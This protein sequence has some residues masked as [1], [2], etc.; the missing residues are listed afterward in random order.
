MFIQQF[1]VAAIFLFLV[2]VTAS[3]C[4]AEENISRDLRR[5]QKSL[6]ASDYENAYKV[7]YQQAI[8]NNN[9]LAEF[10]LALFYE[11]GWGRP[12]DKAAAC[13][14]YGKAAE[15]EIPAAAHFYAQCFE[16]GIGRK[17]STTDAIQW[18]EK[19]IS[20]DHGGSHYPLAELLLSDSDHTNAQQA[21]EHL[22]QAA[23]LGNSDAQME[24]GDF[25]YRGEYVVKNLTEAWHWYSQ[26][27]AKDVV[28]AQYYL[29][30][31][32]SDSDDPAIHSIAEA[33]HWFEAAAAKGYLPAYL[34]TAKL[35][36]ASS[37]DEESG[38]IPAPALAKAYLWLSAADKRLEGAEEKAQCQ[39]MLTD[40]KKIMPESWKNDLDP[41]VEKHI[42]EVAKT[43]AH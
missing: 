32:S 25:Y 23:Q 2:A 5:A 4:L 17:Q 10:T 8:Q 14:W 43:I 24:L 27:A 30:V 9:P 18:Y 15:G 20:L 37:V 12:I 11:N 26:A 39:T 42:A 36:L 28:E 3:G 6:A 22:T 34:P 29:G 31:I 16:Q 38:N 13:Q 19:A 41:K 33:L 21:I 35:Y 1:R 7:Y 40:V